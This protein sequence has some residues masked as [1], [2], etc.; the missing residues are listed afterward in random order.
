MGRLNWAARQ[1][2]GEFDESGPPPKPTYEFDLRRSA[3]P[4]TPSWPAKVQGQTFGPS[5]IGK[6]WKAGLVVVAEI[7]G[8]P[9]PV[10]ATETKWSNGI[11]VVKCAEGWRP[12]ERIW[13]RKTVKGLS[14]CG[15]LLSEEE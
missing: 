10:A 11:L 6:A 8:L 15:E 9:H 14:S 1:S 13:T 7:D 2:P 12:P 3:E 4:G 5:F